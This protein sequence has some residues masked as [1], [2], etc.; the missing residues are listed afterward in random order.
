MSNGKVRYE[1]LEPGLFDPE[2]EGHEQLEGNEWVAPYDTRLERLDGQDTI[3]ITEWDY[4]ESDP[5]PVEFVGPPEPVIYTD[6]E[7]GK[8]KVEIVYPT[9]RTDTFEGEP[10]TDIDGVELGTWVCGR[11]ESRHTT[12]VVNGN[13]QEPHE[14][15][16]CERQGPFHHA[17]LGDYPDLSPAKF[18]NPEWYTP[19]NYSSDRY[20]E[21]WND[22]RE[23]IRT[24]WATPDESLYQ[25][26][27]AFAISTWL[28]PNQRFLSHLLIIGKHETGKTRLLN[29]LARVSYRG[30]VP[31]DYSPAAMYRMIDAYGVSLFLS[32]YHDL[33]DDKRDETNSIIKGSQ[34]RGENVIRAEKVA[35]RGFEPVSFDIFT[36]VGI[37]AQFEPPDDIISRAIQVQTE[38]ADRDIP[39]WFDEQD[40]TDI[41]N[42]LLYARF[43]LL[44]SDAWEQAETE[45]LR[46]LNEQGIEGRLREKLL[47]LVTVAELWD[48]RDD[49]EP[50]VESM[51][52]KDKKAKG[53]SEDALFI[54][55]VRDL[56]YEEVGQQGTLD[57]DADPWDGLTVPLSDVRDRFNK[58]TGRDVTSRYI[59]EIRKRLGLE[60]ARHAD[61]TV[62]KDGDLRE[63]LKKLC[64]EN[65]LDWE[66]HS[67]YHK[68][69]RELDDGEQY[70]TKCPLC[71]SSERMTH[72]HVVEGH[73]MCSEC[74][75][76]HPG[77]TS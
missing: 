53:E 3:N 36:H 56:A 54:Q 28:R 11:C 57:P 35:D 68:E 65:N 24:Y 6:D 29:T 66:E 59:T 14:C 13:I 46:W 60:K 77:A 67:G 34:K 71:D 21:L 50:F 62:I 75:D 31:V 47:S 69:I 48:A 38:P 63:K 41:R 10:S 52:E 42:R 45:A 12:G 2:A 20:D 5:E 19:S 8:K 15:P 70:R 23:W 37:G 9:E 26:L 16:G 73:L 58:M 43:R 18:A 33:K 61:G 74:A 64:E 22:V 4:G 72:K 55:A 25:G 32:E 51:V 40:A 7:T 30:L 39:P 27:T 76:D 49:I 17:G 1:L 44:E